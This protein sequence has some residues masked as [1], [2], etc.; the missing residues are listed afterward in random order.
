V[1]CLTK[2]TT[3]KLI[4]YFTGLGLVL[5]GAWFAPDNINLSLLLA[6]LGVSMAMIV[7]ISVSVQRYLKL[8]RELEQLG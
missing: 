3:F 7:V 6:V 8:K 4:I 1:L 5:T 2:L